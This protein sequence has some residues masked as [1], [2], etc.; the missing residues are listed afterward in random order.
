MTDGDISFGYLVSNE[1]FDPEGVIRNAQIAEREG[2]DSV[3]VSDHFHPWTSSGTYCNFCWAVI[4]AMAERTR[5]VRIGP[6]VTVP[7]LRYNPAIMAQAFATL[8]VMYPKRIFLGIGSGEPVNEMAVGSDWPR[9]P[10]RLE[11]FDEG[12]N[13]IRSLFDKE[14]VNLD[15][16]YYKI[17]TANLYTKP[18]EPVPIYVSTFGPKSAFIAGKYGDGIAIASD[19]DA[20]V[21]LLNEKILPA[22]RKGAGETGRDPSKFKIA[23]HISVAYDEDED[24]ILSTKTKEYWN[25]TVVPNLT[26]EPVS[27][28]RVN[29]KRAELVTNEMFRRHWIIETSPD[30]HIKRIEPFLRLAID[31]LVILSSSPDEK[32]FLQTYGRRVLPYLREIARKEKRQ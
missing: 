17:R 23:V 11:K 8:G 24:R 3:W 10:M 29:A 31:E 25:H 22:V 30:A 2:F 6:G 26:A 15:G 14:F 19:V 27:D 32:K 9:A 12:L 16:K 13:V 5:R 20:P 28:P 18:R 7:G 4:T 21:E 1:V